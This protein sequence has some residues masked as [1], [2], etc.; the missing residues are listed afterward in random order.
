MTIEA[1]LP[2]VTFRRTTVGGA[3]SRYRGAVDEVIDLDGLSVGHI[4][5]APLAGRPGSWTVV[6]LVVRAAHRNRGAGTAALLRWAGVA[7]AQGGLL[8][9]SRPADDPYKDYYL[10]LGFR[11]IPAVPGRRVLYVHDAGVAW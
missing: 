7:R 8:S 10:R 4:L 2:A 11:M 1:V 5:V 9:I 6:E 3:A